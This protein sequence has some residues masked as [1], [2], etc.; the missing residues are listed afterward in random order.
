MTKKNCASIDLIISRGH[1]LNRKT[2]NIISLFICPCVI[3]G[4]Y[5]FLSSAEYKRRYFKERS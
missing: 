5:D 3:P 2:E 1:K 4:P